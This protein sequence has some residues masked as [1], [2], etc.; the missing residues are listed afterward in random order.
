MSIINR[1]KEKIINIYG[2]TGSISIIVA[3][4]LNTIN[5]DN[6]SN[7]DDDGNIYNIIIDLLNIYGSISIGIICYRQKAYQ[8]V[9]LEVLW[10]I[11]S[12]Y[13]FINNI[14]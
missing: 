1:N 11:F 14:T 13:S 10:F 12:I 5:T 6:K 7:N 4:A 8:P 9:L 2:W 3:Y